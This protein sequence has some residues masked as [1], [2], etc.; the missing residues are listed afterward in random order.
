MPS[1][2]G[3]WLELTED[4]FN[5]NSNHFHDRGVQEVHPITGA[6]LGQGRAAI[7]TLATA[8]G[9]PLRGIFAS[10]VG[11]ESGHFILHRDDFPAQGGAPDQRADKLT[12]E[13]DQ[14]MVDAFRV[15]KLI[16]DPTDPDFGQTDIT[17]PFFAN[18]HFWNYRADNL[19]EPRSSGAGDYTIR[20]QSRVKGAAPGNWWQDLD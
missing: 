12:I 10:V 7:T 14:A 15:E 17:D 13:I 8:K 18:V 3:V 2:T 11:D 16:D 9:W 6:N 19:Y 1:V 20:I 4:Q 5:S